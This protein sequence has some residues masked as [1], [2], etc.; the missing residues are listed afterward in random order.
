ML[1]LLRG[2]V[3]EVE[4]GN[5]KMT[6]RVVD[7]VLQSAISGMLVKR[8]AEAH[9]EL[10]MYML[11]HCIEKLSVG[12]V[13]YDPVDLAT[14]PDGKSKTGKMDM[15]DEATRTFFFAISGMVN[16]VIFSSNEEEKKSEQPQ[17]L[18]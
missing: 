3:Q 12:G 18:G 16:T 6:V 1:K 4:R 8:S 13:D 7:T 10:T 15:T 14:S 5:V 11:R 9:A 17:P 2:E